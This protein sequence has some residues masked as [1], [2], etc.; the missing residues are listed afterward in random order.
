MSKEEH[1]APTG[2]DGNTTDLAEPGT[3]NSSSG[4]A[5]EDTATPFGDWREQ[6]RERVKE[7]R[8]RKHAVH[9]EDV[10]DIALGETTTAATEEKLEAARAQSAEPQSVDEPSV[11]LVEGE[12][13]SRRADIAGLVDDLLGGPEPPAEVSPAP[14][15]QTP[16][17]AEVAAEEPVK[18]AVVEGIAEELVME[19]VA[20]EIAEEPVMDAAAE[21]IVEETVMEAAAEAVIEETVMEAAAEESAV[22]FEEPLEAAAAAPA[23]APLFQEEPT[24]YADDPILEIAEEFEHRAENA[25]AFEESDETEPEL[26][27]AIETPVEAETEVE[28]EADRGMD[29]PALPVDNAAL[30]VDDTAIP[31]SSL[32]DAIPPELRDVEIPT[33]A[34]PREPSRAPQADTKANET[35]DDL[36][37]FLVG[38]YTSPEG[39]KR[40]D[41]VPPPDTPIPTAELLDK[42]IGDLAGLS[43]DTFAEE[44]V[45]IAPPGSLVD[46]ADFEPGDREEAP[47][48]SRALPGLFDLADEPDG[49]DAGKPSLFFD[50]PL[51]KRA[52][53]EET[54][55]DDREEVAEEAPPEVVAEATPA[56]V[57]FFDEPAAETEPAEIPPEKARDPIGFFNEPTAGD[58]PAEVVA[59]EDPE[60]VADFQQA[61]AKEAVA[62][63]AAAKEFVSAPL[64][65][66]IAAGT[67]ASEPAESESLEWDIDGDGDADLLADARRLHADA[68]APMSDRVYSAVADGMVLL[69]IGLVLMIAGASAARSPIVPF[70]QAAPIPF[71]AAWSLFGLVYGVIFV[72]TCGQTLGKMAM[73][74]RV[75]GADTF[76]VGYGRAALRAFAYAVAALP[77]GLGLLTALKDP[78]HRGLHDRLTST[79]VV[80]A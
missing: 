24:V 38:E 69:T 8:A 57:A 67:R 2:S 62:P 56:A 43:D 64:A 7:I 66:E 46:A 61:V 20:E 35:D 72:G 26:V 75:I 25:E 33:W 10:D 16:P 80:K 34:L 27:T 3:A 65:D 4:E 15:E 18:E 54:V 6:L 77:A 52:A 31:T 50:E 63:A 29:E 73:R 47:A 37:T 5:P 68:S 13:A 51:A 21:A 23:A 9:R 12:R 14:A 59:K 40:T 45:E 71:L 78:E 53:V 70:V 17:A 74:V 1:V 41:L 22:E 55:E 42:P 30:P 28:M 58:E 48:A 39:G 49:E 19:A 11:Q 44:E 36:D 76:H 60:P 32:L 79:R